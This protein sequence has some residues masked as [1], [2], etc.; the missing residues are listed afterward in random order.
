MHC[1]SAQELVREAFDL[2]LREF[3]MIGKCF[4]SLQIR[5][6]Q[7]TCHPEEFRIPMPEFRLKF[8]AQR[9]KSEGNPEPQNPKNRAWDQVPDEDGLAD[10]EVRQKDLT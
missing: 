9:P 6:Q 3:F 5:G 8:E 4:K 7:E 1:V 2:L 10:R